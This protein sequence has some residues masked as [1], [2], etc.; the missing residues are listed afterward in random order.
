MRRGDAEAGTK[1]REGGGGEV[2]CSIEE[3]ELG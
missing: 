3:D 1:V 2:R